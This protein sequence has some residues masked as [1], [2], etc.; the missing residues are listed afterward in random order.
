MTR[1]AIF[2]SHATPE[3]NE[4]VRWLGGKLE[5]AGYKVWHD[6]D[7]LKGGDYFWEKIEAAIR[8]ESFRFIAVVSKVAIGKR[9]VKAEW[10]LA[11]TIEA[12]LPGFVIPVRVDGIPFSEVPISLHRKNLLDFTSGWHKGL[13]SLIDTLE[14]A[15][16]P[17]VSN[18]DPALA[19]HWL[20]EQ[21]PGAIVR[22]DAKETLDSTWLQILSLPPAIETARILG[23]DREIKVT[24]ENRRL[25]WFEHEDRIVGFAKGTDL[26]SLMAKSAMLKAANAADTATFIR[27]GST[28]GDKEVP[29]W[30]ARKRVGNLVRQAWE[31]A[32]EARGFASVYQASGRRV[33]YATPE[34]TG[35][36]GKFVWYEDFD[37]TKRRKALTGKS[38]KREACWAYGVGMV[39]SFEEP[40]RVELRHAVIFTDDDGKPIEDAL[41]AH[42][43]RRGFCKNWWNEHWRTLMRAFL[44]VASEGRPELLLPVGSGRSISLSSTPIQFE[45]PCGLSDVERVADEEP[46]DE[47]DEDEIAQQ[48]EGEEEGAQ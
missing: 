48:E 39:P 27:E 33:F 47:I 6:L 34:L 43:L 3:D 16:A 22:T 21:K 8:D 19:R 41:K 30:E 13:A 31:L 20:P 42:R 5:L 29:W 17:K 23:R 35:G 14:D 18:P 28:L 32:M 9:G 15:Q 44:W 40:W 38:E 26:V 1:E 36:R 45:A 11:D 4:F 12:S 7:R 37:G 24:E 46:V 25:P 2:I 10:A